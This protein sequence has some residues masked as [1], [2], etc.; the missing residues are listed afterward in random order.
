MVHW[1]RTKKK[2][3][4]ERKNDGDSTRIGVLGTAPQVQKNILKE[5]KIQEKIENMQTIVKI[6]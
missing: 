4:V 2:T 5:L 1:E 6:N 3:T